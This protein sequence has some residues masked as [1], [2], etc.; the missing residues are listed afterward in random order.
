MSKEIFNRIKTINEEI[1][2]LKDEKTKFIE[3]YI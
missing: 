1:D 3:K 2:N